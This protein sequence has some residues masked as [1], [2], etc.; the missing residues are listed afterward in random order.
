VRSGE[1]EKEQEKK[2]WG[3]DCGVV[4]IGCGFE[5]LGILQTNKPRNNAWFL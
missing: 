3:C 1:W 2:E 5:I 4:W